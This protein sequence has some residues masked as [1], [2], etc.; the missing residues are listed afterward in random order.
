MTIEILSNLK[1]KALLSLHHCPALAAGPRAWLSTPWRRRAGGRRRKGEGGPAFSE[2]KQIHRH[3]LSTSDYRNIHPTFSFVLGQTSIFSFV[4]QAILCNYSP[5]WMEQ[6]SRQDW[7]EWAWPCSIKS[8]WW[9]L[10]FEFQNI[11]MHPEICLFGFVSKH[12]KT[13]KPFL[14]GGPSAVRVPGAPTVLKLQPCLGPALPSLTL[15]SREGGEAPHKDKCT[16]THTVIG[17]RRQV[18]VQMMQWTIPW[19]VRWPA[20]AQPTLFYYCFWPPCG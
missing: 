20:H 4:I 18:R 15:G 19:K 17:D 12:L 11:F 2:V 3:I 5:L 9:T 10:K 1:T 14:A 13:L 8:Y 16:Q 7:N 6:T